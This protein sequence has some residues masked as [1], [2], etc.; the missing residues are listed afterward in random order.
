MRLIRYAAVWL[1][2]GGI[3]AVVAIS[4]IGSDAADDVSLP[5]VRQ[6]ELTSAARIARCQLREPARSD[7]LNPPVSGP[8]RA[9]PAEPAVYERAVDPDRLLAALRRGVIVIHYRPGLDDEQVD[10]LSELQRAVPNGTIVTPNASRMPYE[11]A[12][13]AW[14]RLLGCPRV[15]GAAI[16]ALRLFRGRF[17]GQGPDRDRP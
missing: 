16:D 11:I 9:R 4:V 7:A 8:R 2:A 17:I 6:T 12:V 5:P 1:A 10:Q 15:S 13:T 14:K 3:A